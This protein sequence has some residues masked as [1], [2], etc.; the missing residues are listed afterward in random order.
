[1]GIKRVGPGCNC[2]Y[3]IKEWFRHR[4]CRKL[5]GYFGEGAEF[6]ASAYAVYTDHIY[7]GENTV[8]REGTMLY[9]DEDA[10]ISIG[11]DVLLGSGIKMFVNNHDYSDP[12]RPVIDQGYTPSEDIEILSGAWV[13]ANV[14]ILPGVTIGRNTVVGAGA[15]VTR[16]VP[17]TE[18]WAKSPA[19]RIKNRPTS[20]DI[21]DREE[22]DVHTEPEQ[23]VPVHNTSTG[24][25]FRSKR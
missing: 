3:K 10:H 19:R 6:R 16:D 24:R 9:A 14:I 15:V 18:V 1:M 12:T 11:D 13:G 8:I 25:L 22:I 7:I 2:L 23:E 4:K 5:F 21:A 20:K 17:D